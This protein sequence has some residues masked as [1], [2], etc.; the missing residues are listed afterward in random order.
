MNRYI[1]CHYVITYIF[2]IHTFGLS[3]SFPWSPIRNAGIR[4]L[5]RDENQQTSA[6]IEPGI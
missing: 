3:K 2:Y 6:K 1:T 5:K 4:A